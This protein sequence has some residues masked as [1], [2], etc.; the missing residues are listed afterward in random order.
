MRIIHVIDSIAPRVGGPAAIAFGLGIAQADLGHEVHIV[1]SE[2]AQRAS[3][4]LPD[5]TAL[6]GH[7]FPAV[8]SAA[9]GRLIHKFL[10]FREISDLRKLIGPETVVHLHGVWE[11]LLPL[12]A[13]LCRSRRTPYVIAPHS[14]LDPWHRPK[15]RNV[16]KVLF[17]AGWLRMLEL[18]AFIHC[19]SEAEKDYINDY[20]PQVR[21]RVMVNGVFPEQFQR[22]LAGHFT[23]GRGT[24]E[25]RRYILFMSR[26]HPI[27]GALELAE[28]YR[29]LASEINVD[30]VVAGPDWGEEQ[31]LRDFA[32]THGLTERIHLVGPLHGHEKMAALR[33][34]ACFCLPS[35]NEGCSIAI[36]EALAAGLPVVITEACHLPEVQEF[37]AGRVVKKDATEMEAAFRSILCDPEKAARM[38]AC[39][40]GL[41]EEKFSWPR[42]AHCMTGL[43]ESIMP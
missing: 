25:N 23:K 38:S 32:A 40:R 10:P 31:A 12:A 15:W 42:I 19:T 22:P 17:T 39:A 33:D 43:Y 29:R 41:I 5:G 18:A 27:K 11:P 2:E 26:L 9:S 6:P 21:S 7:L 8:H 36:L 20:L 1:C 3:D 14:M 4:C 30:L 34:A 13:S 16:K 24:L 37:G 35:S 28:A